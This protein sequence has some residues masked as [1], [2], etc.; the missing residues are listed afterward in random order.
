MDQRVIDWCASHRLC[1]GCG[2]NCVAPVADREFFD[3]VKRQELRIIDHI[4]SIANPKTT[5]V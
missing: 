1:N 4:E 5:D 3:W 2:I